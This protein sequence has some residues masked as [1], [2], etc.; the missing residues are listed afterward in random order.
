MT[1]EF[2][3]YQFFKDQSYEAVLRF[4]DGKT[5]VE[6]ARS[7]SLS[8]GGRIGT[9][10]RI[11]ITDG[12]DSTV[13]EWKFRVGVTYPPQHKTGEVTQEHYSDDTA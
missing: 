10:D 5:A 1:G 8:V 6:Q 3:V 12:G 13:F 7:L 9:T 2:S 11:I 4:V